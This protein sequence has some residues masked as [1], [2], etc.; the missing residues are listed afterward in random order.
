VKL[1]S[2]V[3][4]HPSEGDDAAASRLDQLGLENAPPD[5]AT[6]RERV[7]TYALKLLGRLIGTIR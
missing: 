3:A 5:M 7:S 4:T 1:L 2:W 6:V